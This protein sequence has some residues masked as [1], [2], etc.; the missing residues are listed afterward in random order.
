M[1]QQEFV[2]SPALREVVASGA[3]RSAIVVG[4]KE[5]FFVRL[6]YGMSEKVLRS[7]RAGMRLFQ[8]VDAAVR[9]LQRCGINRAEVDMTNYEPP[10]PK[11]KERDLFNESV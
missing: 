3:L 7:Q 8:T 9:E 1:T 6:R 2:T 11:A 5:G 4:S 10:K